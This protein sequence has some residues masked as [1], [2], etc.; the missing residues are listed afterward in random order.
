MPLAS[1][2]LGTAI[3]QKDPEYRQ[4]AV[5]ILA[6]WNEDPRVHADF[7]DDLVLFCDFSFATAEELIKSAIENSAA[8]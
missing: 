3:A 1:S 5:A 4:W 8:E 2:F 6:L 7:A